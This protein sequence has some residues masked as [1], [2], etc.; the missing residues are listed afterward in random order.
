MRGV[1][2]VILVGNV[3]NDPDVR[4]MPNGNAVANISIATSET[5][6]DKDTGDTQEKTEWHRVIFFN[7]LAEI[8]EEYVTKGSKLYV[9]GKLQTRSYEQDGVKKYVTEIVA[10]GMQMLDSQQKGTQQDQPG[11]N[12]PPA[13]SQ[14][15]QGA[16]HGTGNPQAERSLDFHNFDDDI[17]F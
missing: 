13:Q 17:P 12:Q 4:Y 9:E 14:R 1:N 16:G 2:K 6:K 5:W 3:G 15:A 7:R 10:N 11:Y 8:V